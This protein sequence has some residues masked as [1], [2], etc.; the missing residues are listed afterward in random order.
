MRIYD[1]NGYKNTNKAYGGIAGQKHG[2]FIENER[3]IIKYPVTTERMHNVQI[4]FT[5]APLSEYLGS[6]V[7]G[8]LGYPVHETVLGVEDGNVVVACKDFETSGL[9]FCE[10]RLAKNLKNANVEKYFAEHAGYNAE[11]LNIECVLT[12]VV[13]GMEHNGIPGAEQR[14]WDQ[15]VIDAFISNSDRN[16]GNW[17]YLVD[18]STGETEMAPVY[19]NASSFFN[20]KSDEEFAAALADLRILNDN[21]IPA[22]ISSYKYTKGDRELPIH[23]FQFMDK[24][25][26]EYPEL[27]DAIVRNS[28]LIDERMDEICAMIEDIPA[29]VVYE[30]K[31]LPVMSD[32]YKEYVLQI[33]EIRRDKL[34]ELAEEINL[35]REEEQFLLNGNYER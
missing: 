30:G 7:Y 14:F 5:T 32:V 10:F 17:G 22:V 1:F 16:N 35:Q 19:D 12:V 4:P 3:W 24:H 25:H 15:F 2:I 27:E 11:T 23:S 21:A 26:E 34:H 8:I 29:N 9:D 31:E 18:V 33:L 6:H 28:A 13:D 20:K